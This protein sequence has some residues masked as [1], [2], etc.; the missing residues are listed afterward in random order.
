MPVGSQ[1]GAPT[2]SYIGPK[3][4]EGS[5]LQ[6]LLMWVQSGNLKRVPMTSMAPTAVV[7]E[8]LTMCNA[9]ISTLP[10]AEARCCG[11][12]FTRENRGGGQ[13]NYSELK[14]K[15]DLLQSSCS[16]VAVHR[17][18][19]SFPFHSEQTYSGFTFTYH[20]AGTGQLLQM[21]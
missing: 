1:L 2:S 13:T 15:K 11:S 14:G 10:L 8:E 12:S 19:F 20:R 5:D 4:A 7:P 17:T 21:I 3:Q 6:P 16:S 9:F 18:N